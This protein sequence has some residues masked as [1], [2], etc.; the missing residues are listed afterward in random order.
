MFFAEAATKYL[1]QVS[2]VIPFVFDKMTELDVVV[3]LGAVALIE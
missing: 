2:I 1:G 3:H